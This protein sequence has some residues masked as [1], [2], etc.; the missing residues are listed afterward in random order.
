MAAHKIS[1]SILREAVRLVKK[2]G[3]IHAASMYAS[4]A[5][6][7]GKRDGHKKG[8]NPSTMRSRLREAERRLGLKAPARPN[9]T[10][11][12]RTTDALLREAV[13]LVN[14]YGGVPA[15]APLATRAD[16]GHKGLGVSSFRQRLKRAEE[17]L[18][19]KPERRSMGGLK[20]R[21]NP[22]SRER[23][24]RMIRSQP[25]HIDTICGATALS[26][27]DVDLILEDLRHEGYRI[28]IADNQIRLDREIQSAPPSIDY[29][30]NVIELV[31]RE[32]NTFCIG[33]TSDNHIGSKYARLDVLEDLYDRFN[34][35][36]VQ[37]AVN[38]GNWI[39]GEARFN[40]HE[41]VDGAH[42]MEGQLALLAEQFP[43]ATYPTYAVTGDDHEG[44]YAQK[45][46]VDIGKRAE[47]TMREAGRTEW[48]DIGYMEGYIRLINANTGRWSIM[49]V[50]HPGGGSAYALSYAIQKIVECV[51]L[52]SEI[53]TEQ[54]WRKWNEVGVG[55]RVLGYSVERDRCKWTTIEAI[56]RGR[57]E[58]FRYMNG[59]FSVE[60]T[61]NHNWA[62][63]W[64]SRAG[65]NPNSREP[66]RYSRRDR[67]LRS[68]A[69][70]KARARII[71][72]A[73]A[74][75]GPGL[76][77]FTHT[78]WLHKDLAVERVLAMTSGER[79]AYIE[80]LL[81]GE[82]TTAN[83]R[84][85][86]TLVFSQ[87]AGPVND[88]FRLACLLEGVATTDRPAPSGSFKSDGEPTRRVTMLKKRLRHVDLWSGRGWHGE[89]LGEKE[90]WCPTTGL[91]T[92]IMRQGDLITITG[93]SLEGG[94]K[95]AVGI[96]GHYHKQMA[97]NIRNVWTVQPGCT[98]DQTSFMRKKK[99]EAHVG[100][101][102]M[103]L[104]QEPKSGAIIGF[105]P[106]MFRYFS[107]SFTP[108]RWSHARRAA[109]PP[110]SPMN[111]TGVKT[112]GKV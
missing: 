60:C 1:D 46:G 67:L 7:D 106:Q 101:C 86:R 2:H 41:L 98:Q 15:A 96:Y 54:G 103:H 91:S 27:A 40:Q 4:Q 11:R 9:Y 55:D 56:H 92:W 77:E 35:I 68:I 63:E 72:A 109:H 26:R 100:G 10:N 36:G 38:G 17:K 66:E 75:D 25:R 28:K 31:S 102:I 24:L 48:H 79:R 112:G 57:A 111:V 84:G 104:E 64:E 83:T 70:T 45:F 21:D 51:P 34:E 80:G 90:V 89:S 65:P 71:Q 85:Y 32:D 14:Q 76:G 5:T 78:D 18:G 8:I 107:R 108:G 82:G 95:P 12:M 53:L 52:E 33:V 49:A 74:V 6:T 43:R 23:I 3:S 29:A 88:S 19:L 42:S 69:E 105:T 99:L 94:E 61:A 110:R 93:N 47:Q 20:P 59:N 13:D 16:T 73:H 37:C 97:C 58:V 22:S 81:V 62:I 50:V 30:D 39:D 44:W 87:R